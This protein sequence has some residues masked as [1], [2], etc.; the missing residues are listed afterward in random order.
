MD[1]RRRLNGNT[2]LAKVE[3]QCSSDTFVV[4]I[5]TFVKPEN[6]ICHYY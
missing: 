6:D 1:R 2:G 5:D 3:V 4:K